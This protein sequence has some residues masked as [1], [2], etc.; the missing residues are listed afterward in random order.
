[1]EVVVAPPQ[2]KFTSFRLVCVATYTVY[3]GVAPI[4]GWYPTEYESPSDT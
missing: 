1:M 3:P 2:P 4:P